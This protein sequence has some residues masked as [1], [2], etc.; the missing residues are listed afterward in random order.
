MK[1][2][3]LELLELETALSQRLDA[4]RLD[5]ATSPEQI[6]AVSNAVDK[7]RAKL[8][9]EKFAKLVKTTN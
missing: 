1:F 6:K 2:T 9:G 4:L 8:W 7:V 5:P 3:D